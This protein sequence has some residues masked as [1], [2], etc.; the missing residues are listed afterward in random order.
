MATSI[1]CDER[2]IKGEVW[3]GFASEVYPPPGFEP[4]GRF[5]PLGG[6][7]SGGFEPLGGPLQERKAQAAKAA[8]ASQG[9]QKQSEASKSKQWQAIESARI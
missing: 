5:E 7:D 1:K 9:K 2:P 8:K 6:F 4:L 3:G